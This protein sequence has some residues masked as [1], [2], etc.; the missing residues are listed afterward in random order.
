MLQDAQFVQ[1]LE[2]ISNGIQQPLSI[3][4]LLLLEKI[5]SGERENI[6]LKTVGHLLEKGFIEL[7]GKTR[8]ARYALARRYYA[9]TGKLGERTR[10]AGLPREKYK[11]WVLKHLRDN[12][13]GTLRELEQLFDNELRRKDISIGDIKNFLS[14]LKREGRI[15]PS[16]K[17]PGAPWAFVK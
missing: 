14:E 9:D 5:R 7:Y 8:G 17:G 12:G 15:A 13:I 6:T 3:E 2:K 10:I 1:Y 4:D 11:E 16:R